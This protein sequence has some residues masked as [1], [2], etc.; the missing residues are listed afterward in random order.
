[1]SYNSDK[2]NEIKFESGL[3]QSRL[4][5]FIKDI[6]RSLAGVEMDFTSGNIHRAILLLAVPMVL[7]MLMESVFAIADIYFV[8]KLGSKAVAAVGIT[9]SV[10]TIVYSLAFALSSAATAIV[11]RRIGEKNPEAASNAA[12]Q[13]ILA[14]I[15]LSLPISLAGIFFADDILRLMGAEKSLIT[16]FSSYTQIMLAG[17]VSIT[18]LFI[19]NGVIR[20]S[21]DAAI[22]LRVLVFGNLINIILDPLLIFGIGPFPEL[23]ITGAAVATNIGRGLAVVFQFY[24]LFSGKH[25]IK[26]KLSSL[27][28]DFKIIGQLFRLS[29][30]SAA[31]NMI[32][33]SSWIFLVR[34]L[35]SF[36][37]EVVAG[38]TVGIRV[39]IFTL[40][41]S[42]GL[43][44][45]ASALVGQNLG[46]KQP[47]R[48]E[49]SVWITARYNMVFLGVMGL[50][51]ILYPEFWISLLSDDLI[52]IKHG[53]ECLQTISYGFISYGFGMVMINSFNGAG[54]TLTPTK[55]CL[56]A[57]WLIEIPLAWL[58]S[59]PFGM[60]Q[61]GVFYSIVIAETCFTLIAV[62]LFRKGKWKE[63]KV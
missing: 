5:R 38:Y 46:A 47:E 28:P 63:M 27:K 30:G 40:L 2:S 45:A 50:M 29:L 33:T 14:G 39:I 48:A 44:N 58:F 4:I 43:S 54:D 53:A 9:E 35:S 25:R 31:Q 59:M 12:F 34:I 10:M 62:Y 21:G 22:S 60:E 18:L 23:G 19:I 42:F 41:P 17:N 55:V 57:F 36:G 3:G 11:S 24:I 51:F 15:A 37:S 26:L 13:S 32:S 61:M 16:A 6:G 49:K 56:I 1:M 20:S 7:E 8:S 52:V